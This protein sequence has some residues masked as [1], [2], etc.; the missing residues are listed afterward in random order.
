KQ[1][2]KNQHNQNQTL[3]NKLLKYIILSLNQNL[4]L[5]TISEKKETKPKPIQENS[6][7]TPKSTKKNKIIQSQ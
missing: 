3:I 1:I 5:K 2:N 4:I 6:H 7:R